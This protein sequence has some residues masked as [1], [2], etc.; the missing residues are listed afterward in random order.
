[1]PAQPRR[2]RRHLV[3]KSLVPGEAA[4]EIEDRARVPRGGATNTKRGTDI[5]G[6]G[7]RD[8]ERDAGASSGAA[9]VLRG[10]LSASAG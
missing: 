10:G 3:G 5:R 2:R 7:A 4:D 8:V 1:M 9:A 6:R